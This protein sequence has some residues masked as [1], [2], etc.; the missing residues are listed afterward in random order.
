MNTKQK[1][2]DY[3]L[4]GGVVTQADG[5]RIARTTCIKDYCGV[6]RR[7]DGYPIISEWRWN[8]DFTKKFKEYFIDN[9]KLV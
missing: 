3:L 2:L 9:S 5:M 1:V 7:K 4:S 8:A 6:L